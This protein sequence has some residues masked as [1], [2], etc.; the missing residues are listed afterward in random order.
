MQIMKISGRMVNAKMKI[1]GGVIRSRYRFSFSRL[2]TS[3]ENVLI[4]FLCFARHSTRYAL[5]NAPL[6]AQNIRRVRSTVATPYRRIS[7]D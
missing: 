7:T 2:F 1:I 5:F 3:C 6:Q 4:C